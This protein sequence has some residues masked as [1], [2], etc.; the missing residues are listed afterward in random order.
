MAAMPDAAQSQYITFLLDFLDDL[1]AG[2]SQFDYGWMHGDTTAGERAVER[3]RTRTPELYQIMQVER[4]AWWA[5]TVDRLLSEG[6]AHLIALGQMHVV[7][8]DSIPRQLERR[9]IACPPFFR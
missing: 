2:R 4:N 3:M 9:G 7:G 1:T 5:R 6:G 8:P